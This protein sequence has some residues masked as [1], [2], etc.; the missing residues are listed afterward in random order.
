[1]ILE[2]IFSEF[3]CQAAAD[4]GVIQNGG[5]IAFTRIFGG[6]A[7]ELFEAGEKL[8]FRE[9]TFAEHREFLRYS[10]PGKNWER[11]FLVW[12]S[13]GLSYKQPVCG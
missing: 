8:Y 3:I 5:I 2:P 10:S 12:A 4:T 9:G 7:L 6:D 11:I 13:G 1:M